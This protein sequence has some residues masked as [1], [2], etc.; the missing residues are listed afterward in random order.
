MKW[1]L[2]IL[3]YDLFHKVDWWLSIY[4]PQHLRDST[5]VAQESA[6]LLV[7]NGKWT[8]FSTLLSAFN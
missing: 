5:E 3:K 6:P 8:E 7:G 4:S 1:K 2:V